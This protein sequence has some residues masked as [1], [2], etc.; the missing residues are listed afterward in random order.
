MRCE[1]AL[2]LLAVGCPRAESPPAAAS[3]TPATRCPAAATH[4]PDGDVC[5]VLPADYQLVRKEQEPAFD[6]R[7][8]GYD[9][10][11]E[12]PAEIRLD[13]QWYP[14]GRTVAARESDYAAELA[15]LRPDAGD[16]EFDTS[17]DDALGHFLRVRLRRDGG[18]E[19][20]DARSLV[21][22][23]HY[24]VRCSVDLAGQ[25]EVPVLDACRTLSAPP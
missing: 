13:L 24:R 10:P 22:T 20:N 21:R 4:T 7:I 2:F 19:E 18:A 1:L 6:R 9:R 14:D 8:Y 17:T 25:P 23:P 11:G 5:L 16:L 12:R 15:H 3:A